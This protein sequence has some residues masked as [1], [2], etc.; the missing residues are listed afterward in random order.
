[1]PAKYFN[2]YEDWIEYVN[3][4]LDE[5]EF[6]I[7]SRERDIEMANLRLQRLLDAA[8]Q[9]IGELESPHKQAS[10]SDTPDT[11]NAVAGPTPS[12]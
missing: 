4:K 9:R 2:N 6:Y 1:V 5:H 8:L 3:A 11:A 12:S 10:G 7:K